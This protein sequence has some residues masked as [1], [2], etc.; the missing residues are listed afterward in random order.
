MAILKTILIGSFNIQTNKIFPKFHEFVYPYHFVFTLSLCSYTVS[1]S[2]ISVAHEPSNILEAEQAAEVAT[3]EWRMR[4][5]AKENERA[6]A[7]IEDGIR[8][9][10]AR[11]DADAEFY[12]ASRLAEADALRLTP[13]YLELERYRAVASNAKVYFASLSGQNPLF[14][15][16]TETQSTADPVN[17]DLLSSLVDNMSSLKN[18]GGGVLTS[19]LKSVLVADEDFVSNG[20]EKNTSEIGEEEP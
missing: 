5:A 1:T 7:T 8:A 15:L 4:M 2:A 17:S 6:I 14:P 9:S 13:R 10:R 3:I 20:G 12:R 18:V 16:S 19:L 11:A